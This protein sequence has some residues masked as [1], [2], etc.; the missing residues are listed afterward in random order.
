MGLSVY[1]NF[2]GN[3]E[4]V[5]HYY[6]NVFATTEPDIMYFKDMPP[7]E[8]MPVTPE[9]ENMVM[10]GSIKFNDTLMMFSDVPPG[11]P[12]EVKFGNNISMMINSQS[13]DELKGYFD[14]IAKE[15]EIIMPYEKTFWSSGY[16]MVTDKFG[17]TWQFNCDEE[18]ED[19]K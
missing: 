5:M 13:F 19:F 16:G 15:G 9:M 12:Q 6:K 8:D 3:S 11:A 18:P 4:E 1:M 17:I 7:S 14:S 10:H 2:P